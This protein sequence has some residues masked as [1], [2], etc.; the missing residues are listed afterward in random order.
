MDTL[1]DRAL[2]T[3]R[4]AMDKRG[5]SQSDLAGIL[6]CSQS[7]VAKLLNKRIMMTVDDL[8]ALCFAVDLSVT[9][10]VRDRGYEF[11]SEMTPSELRFFE[12]YK[13]L[14][15]EDR[16]MVEAFVFRATGARPGDVERRGLTDKKV[17]RKRKGV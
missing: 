8:E 17:T 16:T 6:N 2:A 5:L 13:R 11:V 12:L 3:I 10:T 15:I 14:R 9:E 4:E 1:A 7:R